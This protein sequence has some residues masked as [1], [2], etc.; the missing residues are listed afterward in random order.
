MHTDNRAQIYR[1]M[2]DLLMAIQGGALPALAQYGISP[3][4]YQEIL[5]ELDDSGQALAELALPPLERAF[6][7]DRTG[8]VAFDC[9]PTANGSTRVACQLWSAGRPGEL[10]LLADYPQSQDGPLLLFRLLEVQ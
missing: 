5:E 2:G 1:L 3:A 6:S 8:R 10:T 9:Y 7:A 4:I